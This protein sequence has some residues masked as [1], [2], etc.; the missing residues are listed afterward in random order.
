M[1]LVACEMGFFTAFIDLIFAMHLRPCL[2]AALVLAA[3]SPLLWGQN[4]V[5]NGDFSKFST[6]EN[7]WD[8]VDGD[9]FLAGNR[10]GG[11]AVMESGKVGNLDLPISVSFIDI[12]GDKLPDL[13]TADPA[14]ILRAYINSGTL[15]EPKFNHAEIIPLFPP[16]IAKDEKWDRGLWTWHHGIPKIAFFDWNRRGTFDLFI[17]NYAGDILKVENAGSPQQPLF[18]QPA[19]YAS[20]NVPTGGKRQWGNLFAPAVVDWNKDGKPDLLIGEGSYSANAVYVLL[21]QSSGAEPKFSEDQRHYLCYGDGREQ[22]V[23]T[24]VDYNGDGQLDVLAGDRKGS[25]AVF[26]NP[27]N[28]KPGT[29]LPFSHDIDF[30]GSTTLST[31][32]AP[33]AAD[34]NGDGLFD[35][36]IGKANGRIAVAINSGTKTVPKFGAPTEIK[37]VNL[38]AGDVRPPAVWNYD[39]GLNRGNLYANLG[40][41]EEASPGGGRI[42]KAGYSRTPN[43]VFKMDELS[44]DGRDATEYF[45][46]WLDEWVPLQAPWAGENR[47]TNAFLIRQLL[48]PLKVGKTYHLSFKVRGRGI[49]NGLCTIAFLGANENKPSKFVKSERG[50]KPVKDEAKEE[51]LETVK[52]TSA[53]EWTNIEQTVQVRFRD[54]SIRALDTTTLAML[55]FKFELVKLYG[56]GEPALGECEICDVQLIEKAGN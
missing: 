53:K 7:L 22:L 8:G 10:R 35:L 9:G 6:V 40:V 34:Y 47:A 56:P 19:T 44:I 41:T 4:V 26:L 2:A 28:W 43:V 54:R 45:G 38:W 15:T 50:S 21:N 20:V 18:Q 24:V 30:G 55:E 17:G 16:Q 13:L 31:A 39:A 1:L 33:F 12:N 42:L 51:I 29:E 52:F 32:I 48:T 11:Y 5:Q 36:I 3:L 23:P 37:G 46:Y 25:V 49:Q 14:G 27:G